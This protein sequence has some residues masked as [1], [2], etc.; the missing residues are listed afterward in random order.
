MDDLLAAVVLCAVLVVLALALAGGMLV[1][2]YR[3]FA[4]WM[5]GR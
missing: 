5:L 4:R 3:A 2:G 1:A